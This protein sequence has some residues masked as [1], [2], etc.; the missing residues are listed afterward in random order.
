MQNNQ[1]NGSIT[2]TKAWVSKVIVKYNICPF[3][4]AEVEKC[5]VRYIKTAQRLPAEVVHALL[6]EFHYLDNHSEV[7]T[8]LFI[9]EEGFEG[10]Y[11]FL[12]LVDMANALIDMQGYEGIYQ[13]A[14]FHPDYCFS[15]EVQ[16]DASNYTNR[17]PY[18]TLHIIRESTMEAAIASHPDADA[19]PSRNI[20]FCRKKGNEFFAELLA[21]CMK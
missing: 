1:S 7:E 21:S 5:S 19:I 12:D 14:S 3:A 2:A 13:L 4:R 6:S 18:P 16:S 9:I 15:G 20:A 11:L 17:S 10:F 8:T